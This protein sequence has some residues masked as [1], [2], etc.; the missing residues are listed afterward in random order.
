[1]YRLLHVQ[2]VY[3]AFESAA[4]TYK[5]A[6]VMVEHLKKAG[7]EC[8]HAALYVEFSMLYYTKSEYDQAY[9]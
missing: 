8:N 6:L 3:C 4:D 2:A 7:Y 1:M 5:L 9:R